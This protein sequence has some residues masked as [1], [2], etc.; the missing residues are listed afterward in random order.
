MLFD[1]KKKSVIMVMHY[2]G[3]PSFPTDYPCRL[4]IKEDQLVITRI[5]PK[6]V[7]TLPMDRI[8]SFTA[9]EEK[10]FMQEYHGYSAITSKSGIKKYYLVIKYD[11][12]TLAFWGTGTD[13][14]AFMKLQ[15]TRF[16]SSANVEL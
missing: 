14:G 15:N 11:K 5:K 6:T 8:Y 7:V 10:R 13:Y 16:N 2:E 1:K 4:E 9:M 12:G 3:I